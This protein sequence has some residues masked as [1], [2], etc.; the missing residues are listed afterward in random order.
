VEWHRET[1][2]GA[3]QSSQGPVVSQQGEGEIFFARVL[4]SRRLFCS[5]V[6]TFSF[7]GSMSEFFFTFE[8]FFFTFVLHLWI[9]SEQERLFVFST[10]ITLFSFFS[11]CRKKISL[12]FF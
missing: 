10:G 8:L 5:F 11:N 7:A 1:I 4:S 12:S 3:K 9:G 2:A 6:Y